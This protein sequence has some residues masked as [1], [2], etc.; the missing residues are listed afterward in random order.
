MPDLPLFLALWATTLLAGEHLLANR[1]IVLGAGLPGGAAWS[2]RCAY[3][4][5]TGGVAF[6]FVRL[7]AAAVPPP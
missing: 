6:A 1:E 3:L 7:F 5:G 2:V 4:L